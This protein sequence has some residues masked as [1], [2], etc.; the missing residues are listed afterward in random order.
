MVEYI[1]GINGIGK[2][3][4]MSEAAV[5]T[6]NTSD[7]HVVYVDCT[8]KLSC[9]LPRSIRLINAGDYEI[10]SV[11]AL[12]GFLMGLCASDY[13]LTDIFVDSALDMFNADKDEINDF[14]QMIAR[15][16]KSSGVNFHFSISD[17]KSPQPVYQ[18]VG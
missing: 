3:R 11:S 8:D 17:V 4:I 6:A 1:T 10:D 13:D 15:A 2:T 16:S 7:G 14:L 12:S 18:S 5:A 9:E